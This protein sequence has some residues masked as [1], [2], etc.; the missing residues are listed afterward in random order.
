MTRWRFSIGR[1]IAPF[2]IPLAFVL[3]QLRHVA[4]ITGIVNLD[5]FPHVDWALRLDW[6]AWDEF[7]GPIHPSGLAALIRLGL[8]L[9]ADSE[10]V[11]Q[12]LSMVGAGLGL[13][14]T[15][16]LASAVSRSIGFAVLCQ[17]FVGLHSEYLLYGGREGTDTLAAGFQLLALGLFARGLAG[18]AS[19]L[20]SARWLVG[21]ALSAGLGYQFRYVSIV[22][23]AVL[24]LVLVALTLSSRDRRALRSLAISGAA[25]VAATLPQW[26]PAW[27]AT[28]SP[29]A[30]QGQNVWFHVL[31]KGDYIS[32]WGR[33][34]P[35]ITVV[36]VIGMDPRLFLSH[37][38]DNFG[39][40]WFSPDLQILEVP[41]F[42]IGPAGVLYLVLA[43]RSVR[44]AVRLLL[45]SF[46]LLHAA[47]LSVL[48]LDRRFLMIM[49]PPYTVGAVFLATRIARFVRWNRGV[50]ITAAHV[51]AALGI[52]LAAPA[53]F[54]YALDQ[55]RM[56]DEI[57]LINDVL[58]SAGVQRP[59]EV[60]STELGLHDLVAPTRLRYP[61]AYW[62]TPGHREVGSLVDDARSRGFNFLIY[63]R[64]VGL[65]AADRPAPSLRRS[66]GTNTHLQ[67][68]E[69][70]AGDL[71]SRGSRSSPPESG[72][73]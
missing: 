28:G 2:V 57:V 5:Y 60:L 16:A 49:I 18:Q 66:S 44:P 43:G 12:A 1:A 59:E 53:G 13:M 31:Q 24:G 73:L 42:L 63:G 3:V 37:W 22:T 19:G 55:P 67:Q 62:A 17:A 61:Q 50:P 38:L 27:Y 6:G 8:D 30:N 48:Y 70:G 29:L 25:F 56:S 45:L 68:S 10:R 41:L 35:G 52:A 11:G 36:D 58:H 64:E 14:G 23:A 72:S 34:P 71:S 4:F 32:E 46:V 54:R 65:P 40:F 26:L 21:G 47:A 69:A 15:Y 39:R 33:A 20:P 9:G 7:F 51:A